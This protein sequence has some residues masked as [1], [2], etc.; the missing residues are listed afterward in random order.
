MLNLMSVD[1]S[2]VRLDEQ[3]HH[4][5]WQRLL[6]QPVQHRKYRVSRL[7]GIAAN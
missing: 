6:T 4:R 3:G 5:V 2:V 1:P 7:T